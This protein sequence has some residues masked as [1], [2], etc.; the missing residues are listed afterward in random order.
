MQ[1]V[2]DLAGV[3]RSLVSLVFQ[4]ADNVSETRR[5]AVLEAA[6][7][8]GYRPNRLARNL[9][10]G[11]SMTV[12]VV[13]DDLQNPYFSTMF[14]GLE[15]QLGS[16][17]YQV[18][19]ANGARDSGRTI[20]A[21]TTFTDLQVDGL[22]LVAPRGPE[23]PLVQ[24]G[25]RMP[26]VLVARPLD[27]AVVDSVRVDERL[28]SRLAVEHLVRLGHRKIVHIDGGAGAAA[29]DRTAGYVNAMAELGLA[30]NVDVLAGEFTHEAGTKAAVALA[31]R[32]HMP[33]AVFAGNDLIASGLW[34]QLTTTGYTIPDEL[35]LIG[36]DDSSVLGLGDVGLTTIRQPFDRIGARAA[37]LLL[38]RIDEPARA[39]VHE[40]LPPSLI[41]R[42]STAAT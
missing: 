16:A 5:N 22:V 20:H 36:F 33:T 3:S 17:G 1:D 25:E 10:T 13:V 12:G 34:M 30:A 15:R 28:G 7:Q 41:E 29:D 19:L 26:T 39:S 9:A 42:S 4:G 27:S 35:S 6:A 11:Q 21:A 31:A 2:A 8:L 38:G 40:A 23:E 32:P 37:E 24:L 18:I 14:D